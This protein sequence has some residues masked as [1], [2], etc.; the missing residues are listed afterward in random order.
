MK[1]VLNVLSFSNN[2]W[3]STFLH[4]PALSTLAVRLPSQAQA[5]TISSASSHIS[6]QNILSVITPC[7]S[8]KRIASQPK[9]DPKT[10]PHKGI[11]PLTFALRVRRS[12]P[13]LERLPKS[14]RKKSRWEY[15][16]EQIQIVTIE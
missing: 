6:Y 5:P 7:I 9:R 15:I 4:F 13:E 11:E 2:W 1:L 14:R 8:T 16:S 3:L 10:M 12:T